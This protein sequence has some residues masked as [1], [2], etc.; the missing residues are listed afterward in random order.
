MNYTD[1]GR[2]K[3]VIG[4][5]QDTDDE[6]LGRAISAASRAIDRYCTQCSRPGESDDYFMAETVAAEGIRAFVDEGGCVKVWPHKPIVNSVTSFEYRA[7]PLN[8]WTSADV[9]DLTIDGGQVIAWINALSL[10]SA[11]PIYA[12]LTY[13]GG[14]AAT[15][16][17]LPDDL[18]DAATVWAV[19][20]YNE[21]K[22]GLTDVIGVTEL[23][24]V[25]FS[26]QVPQRVELL[27]RP[28]RRMPPW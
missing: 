19:R 9:T 21:A 14:F 23:G 17:A 18:V 24:Q 5:Q 20:F 4:A 15:L 11:R 25:F 8:S 7:N 1:L 27:L 10:R 26:K 12:R 6:H 3:Q 16:D 13:N 28:Y 2:V 22:A